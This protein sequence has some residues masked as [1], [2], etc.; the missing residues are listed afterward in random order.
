VSYEYVPSGFEMVIAEGEICPGSSGGTW[1]L[2]WN[3]KLTD[4]PEVWDSEI[5]LANDMQDRLGELTVDH[6]LIRAQMAEFCRLHPLFPQSVDILCEEIGS[7]RFSEPVKI[8]CEGRALL[9]TLGYHHSQSLEEQRKQILAEYARALEKWV[10]QDRPENAWE[11]KVFGFLGQPTNSKGAFVEKLIAAIDPEEPS[12]SSLKELGENECRATHSR[13]RPFNCFT[14]EG[15]QEGASGSNCQCCY[16]MILDAGL[17]C[18]VAFGA[19][20]VK[21]GAFDEFRRFTEEYILAYSAAINSWL[22]G[23]PPQAVT[24][25]TTPRYIAEENALELAERVHCALG[26]KDEAKEWLAACLLKTIKDNQRWH[27]RAEL[28][29]DFPEATSWFQTEPQHPLAG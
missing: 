25:L 24:S 1:N 17:L 7:G 19:E 27:K 23:A 18:A 9:D 21:W 6:R 14:C 8:G 16:A 10:A 2:W 29:D 5:K 4:D 20:R 26:E 15:S 13:F 11:S 28:L 22:N 12:I 3:V